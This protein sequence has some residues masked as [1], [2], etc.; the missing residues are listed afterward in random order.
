[1]NVKPISKRAKDRLGAN[2]V[3][4]EIVQTLSI[5]TKIGGLDFEKPALIKF[6]G[7]DYWMCLKKDINEQLDR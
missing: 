1:M 4:I 2:P 7:R 3:E 6:N 5:P